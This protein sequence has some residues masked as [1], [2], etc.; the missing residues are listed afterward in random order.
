MT[1]EITPIGNRILVDTIEPVVEVEERARKAGLFVAVYDHN[2]PK[3]TEGIVVAIGSDPMVQEHFQLGDHVTFSK[4]SGSEIQVEGKTYRQLDFQ[5][6][7]TRIRRRATAS[8]SE[9]SPGQPS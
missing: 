2:R 1:L 4:F 7:L 8:E 6:V 3:P 9:A 5:E